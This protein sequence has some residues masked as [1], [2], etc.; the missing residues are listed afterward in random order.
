VLVA[1]DNDGPGEKASLYWLDALPNASRWRPTWG[2]A[3]AMAQVGVDIL[4]WVERGLR[5]NHYSMD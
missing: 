2:D 5:I 3:N 4:A 1:Y